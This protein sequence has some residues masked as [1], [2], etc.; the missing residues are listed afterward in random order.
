MAVNRWVRRIHD[1]KIINY[2]I[3]LGKSY[4]YIH[5]CDNIWYMSCYGIFDKV[6][7]GEMS[8]TEAQKYA[9]EKFAVKLDDMLIDINA[10]IKDVTPNINKALAEILF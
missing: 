7:L 5:H 8:L 1:G 3:K 9:L 2:E 4:L 10:A 6:E